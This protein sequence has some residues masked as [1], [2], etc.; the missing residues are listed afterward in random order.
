MQVADI[1]LKKLKFFLFILIDIKHKRNN[2]FTHILLHVYIDNDIN[3][4]INPGNV[5]VNELVLF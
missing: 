5:F 1:I 3:I 2:L 4:I